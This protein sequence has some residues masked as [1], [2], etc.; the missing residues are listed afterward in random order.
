MTQHGR[1]DICLEETIVGEVSTTAYSVQNE[2]PL[3]ILQTFKMCNTCFVRWWN[4][5]IKLEFNEAHELA[6]I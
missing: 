6:A 5:E 2:P 1:C 3:S 4:K